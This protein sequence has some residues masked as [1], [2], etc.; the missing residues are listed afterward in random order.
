MYPLAL[1]YIR[2]D[3]RTLLKIL[4]GLRS[5]LDET[6][7]EDAK[8]YLKGL[9]EQKLA[10][11][12]AAENELKASETEKALAIYEEARRKFPDDTALS[13]IIGETLLKYG[14]YE[15]AVLTFEGVIDKDPTNVQLYNRIGMACRK[16]KQFD[17]AEQHFLKAT[18]Y[19]GN[20]VNLLFN[21][22]R[23]YVD[24]ENWP[25]ALEVAKAALE[26]QPDFVEAQRMATYVQ[27]KI[28][29]A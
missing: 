3:E 21:L 19:T 18:Q 29:E 14:L 16:L 4:D 23:V 2:G 7:H 20:N 11:L 26:L 15:E 25:K 27:K 22:G 17:R 1:Q 8:D 10:L 9:E 24:A 6:I 28:N 5:V 13:A 12:T